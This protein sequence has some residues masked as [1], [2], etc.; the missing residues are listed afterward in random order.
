MFEYIHPEIIYFVE[1][2]CNPD[3]SLGQQPIHFYS[4]TFITEGKAYYEVDGKPW[5]A[6]RGD[7]IFARPGS[8]RYATTTG[9]HCVAV[10]FFLPSYQTID[11]F[12]F[13][14]WSNMNEFRMAFTDINYEWLQK[15]DGY[16][17]KCQALLMLVLHKLIYGQEKGNKNIYV[18]RIKH[19]IMEN[20]MES[21]TV[22]QI[23]KYINLNPTYCGALFK[24]VEN[25][26]ITD[27]IKCLRINQAKAFLE[28]GKSIT[29]A[30]EISGFPNVHY[31]SNIFKKSVGISPSIYKKLNFRIK[32]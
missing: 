7:I 3:W 8:T 12:N 6:K 28:T 32:Y 17:M 1:K 15:Q 11:L 21:I 10:D 26:T 23:A 13:I 2:D 19:F 31:F 5:N 25:Q 9:M 14:K 4:L 29:E 16:M 20:Y 22:E 27:F 24:K 18:E 30:A